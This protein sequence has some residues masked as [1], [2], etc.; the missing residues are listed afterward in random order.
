MFDKKRF[1]E[2]HILTLRTSGIILCVNG[3]EK[4]SNFVYNKSTDIYEHVDKRRE[5]C[6]GRRKNE[7]CRM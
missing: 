3:I 6:R 2:V 4:M 1:T 7:D 5:K